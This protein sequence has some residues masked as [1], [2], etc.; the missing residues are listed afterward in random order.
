[1]TNLNSLVGFGAG[2]GGGGDLPKAFTDTA[3]LIDSKSIT[4]TSTDSTS[5]NT[6][7]KIWPLATDGLYGG[8]IDAWAADNSVYPAVYAVSFLVSTAN[9]S[10]GTINQ[11]KN[12]GNNLYAS[13]S[14]GQVYS[15]CHVGSVGNLVLIHGHFENPSTNTTRKGY[16]YGV[17]FTNT[18]GVSIAAGGHGDENSGDNWPHSNGDLAM[19]TDSSETNAYFRRS[20]YY[21]PQGKYYHSCAHWSTSGTSIGNQ[22]H[23]SNSNYTSTNYCNGAAKSSKD[24]RTPGGFIYWYGSNGQ[25]TMTEIYGSSASRSSDLAIPSGQMTNGLT[26]HM[27]TGK[28]L[29]VYNGMTFEGQNNGNA[30]V[31]ISSTVDPSIYLLQK[32]PG[33]NAWGSV[34]FQPTKNTDEWLVASNNFG[35]LKIFIDVNDNYKM[36][37]SKQ[38]YTDAW[39]WNESGPPSSKPWG[40][41]GA[42]DE[43]LVQTEWS[44]STL[45]VKS[46]ENPML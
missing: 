37:I 2:G 13:S 6:Y 33:G 38:I 10:I 29:R 19:G 5:G 16:A 36:T 26:L 40:L 20:T 22:E 27:S 15:T 30:P 35:L 17:R 31:D 41:T 3:T 32:A 28:R 46:Y 43:Y 7:N 8:L 18:G 24:D 12:P 25:T 34:H 9:G 4:L 14:S 42:N 21:S 44:G 39:G 23:T 1:M 45:T 11:T